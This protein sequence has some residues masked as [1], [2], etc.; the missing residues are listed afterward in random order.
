MGFEGVKRAFLGAPKGVLSEFRRFK[1][2]KMGF[3]GFKR[4]RRG[5][6]FYLGFKGEFFFE[7]KK[8]IQRGIEGFGGCFLGV[9]GGI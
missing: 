3:R 8:G 9:Q 5:S 7:V 4:V 6:S 2:V 1:G